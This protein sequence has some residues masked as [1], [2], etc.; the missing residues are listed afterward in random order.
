MPD[1]IE[2]D[3]V[4]ADDAL[5][6]LNQR[7]AALGRLRELRPKEKAEVVFDNL[8]RS[9]HAVRRVVVE[10]VRDPVAALR[11]PLIDGLGKGACRDII[12]VRV[13]R[14]TQGAF[15]KTIKDRKSTRPNS[16]HVAI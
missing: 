13:N 10:Q 6:V 4:L 12:P 14:I 15:T 1:H 7:V 11:P 5:F 16:S 8:N 3:R 2:G 9:P